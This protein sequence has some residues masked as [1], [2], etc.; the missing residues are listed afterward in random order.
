[1]TTLFNPYWIN[2]AISHNNVEWEIK[3]AAVLFYTIPHLK[4]CAIRPF[5]FR[6]NPIKWPLTLQ[7][8]QNTDKRKMSPSSA[9]REFKFHKITIT[10]CR[11]LTAPRLVFHLQPFMSSLSPHWPCKSQINFHFKCLTTDCCRKMPSSILGNTLDPRQILWKQVGKERRRTQDAISAEQLW[12]QTVGGLS[13]KHVLNVI[14][15]WKRRLTLNSR[16]RLVDSTGNKQTDRVML[17]A[18]TLSTEQDYWRYQYM[19]LGRAQLSME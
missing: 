8:M 11:S 17:K 9:R 16:D 15:S 5:S 2:H 1:M 6:F 3:G 18:R 13:W 10:V 19:N 4:Q 12:G 14:I 7:S